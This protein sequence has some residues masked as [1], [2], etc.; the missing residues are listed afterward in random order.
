MKVSF[1]RVIFSDSV[2]SDLVCHIE[3]NKVVKI[4]GHGKELAFSPWSKTVFYKGAWRTY[5]HHIEGEQKPQK[6]IDLPTV[7]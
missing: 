7:R 5:H 2:Q 4:F 3:N 6:S 1:I